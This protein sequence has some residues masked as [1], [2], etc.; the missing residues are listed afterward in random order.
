MRVTVS[1]DYLFALTERSIRSLLHKRE[2][3][4]ICTYDSA[5]CIDEGQ[6]LSPG[7]KISN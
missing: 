2:P 3:K 5:Y 7:A 6:S 4:G 1:T